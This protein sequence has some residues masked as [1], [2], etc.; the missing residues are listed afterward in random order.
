MIN[1]VRYELILVLGKSE[2]YEGKLMV[3]FY[4]GDKNIDDLFLD[5]QG[6][7]ISDLIVNEDKILP[8]NIVFNKHKI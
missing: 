6:V 1:N 3:E 2:N 4:L 8:E 7:G 5:F